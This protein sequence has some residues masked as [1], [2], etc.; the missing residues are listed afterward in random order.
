[1]PYVRHNGGNMECISISFKSAPEEVRKCF[2]F[3]EEEKKEI[4]GADRPGGGA[5]YL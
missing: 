3:S 2:V 4:S 5:Q 1:M